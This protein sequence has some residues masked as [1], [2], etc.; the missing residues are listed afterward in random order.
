MTPA[1][2]ISQILGIADDMDRENPRR[3]H[4]REVMPHTHHMREWARIIAELVERS[5]RQ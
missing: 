4:Y 2:A 1:E 3:E 5:A